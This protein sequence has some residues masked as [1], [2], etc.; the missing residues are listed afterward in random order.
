MNKSLCKNL[1][2]I[3]YRNTNVKFGVCKCYRSEDLWL[4]VGEKTHFEKTAFKNMYCNWNL[5]TQIDKGL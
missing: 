4:S 3:D 5:L 2:D 1:Q